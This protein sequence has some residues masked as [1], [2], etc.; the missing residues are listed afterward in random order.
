[1]Q[2]NYSPSDA[3]MFARKQ[4]IDYDIDAPDVNFLR[5]SVTP[6]LAFSYRIIPVLAETAV[7]RPWKY[8]KYAALGYAINKIGATMGGGE[9]DK[10]RQLM[11][12]TSAGNILG[13]PILPTKEIKLPFT[14][15]QGNSKY[16]NIQRLF[17]GGDVLELGTG[18]IP[19]LPAPLQPS[20]GIGGD[21]LFGLAGVDLF[22]KKMD[23]TRG[24]SVVED[25]TGSLKS[26]G[27][28]LIP[29][30][31]FLP[32]SYSTKR[33]ER[34]QPGRTE[35]SPFREP[36]SELQAILNAFGIKVTNRSLTSLT[37]TKKAEL[38]RVLKVYDRKTKELGKKLA[39][40]EI[41]EQQFEDRLSDIVIDIQK[42]VMI[43]G[44]RLEGIDPA[45]ILQS[46]EMID[47][48]NQ[49]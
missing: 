20:F 3:A 8:A 44:G 39:S 2:Q 37:V 40:G 49:R 25:V 43:F 47:L 16:I 33:I 6:F 19:G 10:E 4:F 36:E 9:A 35:I 1:M 27:V 11:P 12:K 30:F 18:V 38:D 29:N 28:K 23:Q 48:M 26:I 42:Q 17:P 46:E 22:T 21:I 15:E 14:D 5:H 13:I 24:I 34:A 41:T 45:T 32:G 31:P 7:V